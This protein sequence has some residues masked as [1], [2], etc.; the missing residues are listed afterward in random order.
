M[1]RLKYALIPTAHMHA[2]SERSAPTEARPC[3]L[4]LRIATPHLNIHWTKQQPYIQDFQ[5]LPETSVKRDQIKLQY[6][7]KEIIA[8]A[9][10]EHFISF[11][12]F[13]LNRSQSFVE[14]C[15]MKRGQDLHL[16]IQIRH[17]EG[18]WALQYKWLLMSQTEKK[19]RKQPNN[20]I[21]IKCL[22][23][24]KVDYPKFIDLRYALR[25]VYQ[26]IHISASLLSLA[27]LI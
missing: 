7:D 24:R 21:R 14:M 4:R 9:R 15:G 2:P 3:C 18:W 27:S 19:I 8:T 1:R 17:R 6:K 26:T 13:S 20:K 10:T 22:T 5:L 23:A 11:P 16:C 25:T 12:G